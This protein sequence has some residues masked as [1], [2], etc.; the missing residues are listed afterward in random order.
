MSSCTNSTRSAGHD[1]LPDSLINRHKII[2]LQRRDGCGCWRFLSTSVVRF[3]LPTLLCR[4]FASSISLCEGCRL[5]L[6]TAPNHTAD[7][8]CEMAEK[9][10]ESLIQAGLFFE[11]GLVVINFDLFLTDAK[12]KSYIIRKLVFDPFSYVYP[13]YWYRPLIISSKYGKWLK[14]RIEWQ[15]Q[16]PPLSCR[17]Y[18][19]R[20]KSEDWCTLAGLRYSHVTHTF[21]QFVRPLWTVFDMMWSREKFID[22]REGLLTW[23][24]VALWKNP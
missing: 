11:T 21:R 18:E 1:N 22:F 3:A 9:D 23:H 13:A 15:S 19:V 24:C 8:G 16:L 6:H 4:S 14:V 7:Y 2:S 12:K 5:W 20:I 17:V 10:I